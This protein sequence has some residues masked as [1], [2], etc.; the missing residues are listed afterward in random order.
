MTSRRAKTSSEARLP[1]V[2]PAR[3]RRSRDTYGRILDAAERQLETREFDALRIEEI[4]TDSGVSAG[5]FYARFTGK[6]ALLPAL[7]ERYREELERSLTRPA[8]RAPD[9]ATL[10]QR[11][12]IYVANRLRRLRRR[13]GLLRALVLECRRVPELGA[14]V[15]DVTRR[16]NEHF[17]AFFLPCRD[18]ITDPERAILRGIYFI[19]A[20]CRDRVLFASSPHAASVPMTLAEFEDE[21]TRLLLAYLRG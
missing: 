10:E 11:A 14:A 1:G 5:S 4:L 20:A 21:A 6:E 12:R 8:L 13:R 2:L 16:L 17:V 7:I 3:Q 18:E 15:E 19:A 9:D